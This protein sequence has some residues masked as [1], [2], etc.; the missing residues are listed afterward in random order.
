MFGLI[1]RVVL[2]WKDCSISPE[3][4]WKEATEPIPA[5]WMREQYDRGYTCTT[6]EEG[7][8]AYTTREGRAIYYRNRLGRVEDHLL[9]PIRKI[10]VLSSIALCGVF[11]ELPLGYANC[12]LYDDR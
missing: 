6:S 12:C 4:E 5:M 11:H 8:C 9:C 2:G 7:V 1:G 10:C 3:D